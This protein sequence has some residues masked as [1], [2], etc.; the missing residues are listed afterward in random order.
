MNKV[1]ATGGLS[2]RQLAR[3]PT[4]RSQ[5]RHRSH[6]GFEP[7]PSV[8]RLGQSHHIPVRIF[9]LDEGHAVATV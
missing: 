6:R 9:D 8:H 2:L 1:P 3:H 5:M 4:F 7:P